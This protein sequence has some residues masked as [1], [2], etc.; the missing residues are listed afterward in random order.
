MQRIKIM[1]LALVAV[2]AIGATAVSSA[3]AVNLLVLRDSTGVV[4]AGTLLTAASTNLTTVTAAGNLECEHNVLPAT[5][6]NNNA[7][8]VKSKAAEELSFGDYLGIEG[9]C[10]TSAAGP[11]I[12]ITQDFPWPEEYKYSGTKKRGEVVVKGNA[13]GTKKVEFVSEFLALEG[14]KNKCTFTA[15]KLL[16]T[17]PVGVKGSPVPLEFTTTNQIFKLN[18][19]AP[20]TAA[21]CPTEG[22]LSGNWAST[23]AHGTVS[24]EL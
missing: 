22:K 11:A 5:L 15:A 2:A 6:E 17:F 13:L 7:T 21:I 3:S 9:A 1:G 20:D 24:V 18:K 23:D 10:K 8:K 12:I 4:P 14:P 19:K 16:S